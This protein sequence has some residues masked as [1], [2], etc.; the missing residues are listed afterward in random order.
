MS[1]RKFLISKKFFIHLVIMVVVAFALLFLAMKVLDAFTLHGEEYSLPN[2]TGLTVKE[3]DEYRLGKQME[4]IIIDSVFDGREDPGTILEQ[5]PKPGSKVKKDRNVYL[6]IVTETPE[7]VKMPNLLDLTLRQSISLLETYGLK[8]NKLEYIQDL[9][10]NAVLQQVHKGDVIPPGEEVFKGS[11]I[12]LILGT[13]RKNNNVRVP[14]V[15]G[16]K[17][18][19]ARE[20]LHKNSLNVGQQYFLDSKDTN[21]LRIYS[22]EPSA[23]E[24][25]KA[26]MGTYVDLY[27]RSDKNFDFFEL[28]KE[29]EL[30][31][32]DTIQAD[33]AFIS[34]DFFNEDIITE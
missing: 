5:N 12:D 27:Y 15:I 25:A 28:I 29:I 30:R 7:K 4:F 11:K 1:F 24:G 20:I 2:Y 31:R 33:S 32:A 21:H 14:F 17:Q 13:G 34:D 16:K 26:P 10:N 6:T 23:A 18:V 9:A 3:L 22:T 19:Q 8:V